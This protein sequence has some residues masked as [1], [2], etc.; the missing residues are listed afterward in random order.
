MVVV[1]FEEYKDPSEDDDGLEDGEGDGDDVEEDLDDGRVEDVA[2]LLLHFVSSDHTINP[3]I[4]FIYFRIGYVCKESIKTT[5][6]QTTFKK[7]FTN[8][9]NR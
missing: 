1:D 7:L 8:V 4:P 6:Q 3:Y 2:V 9:L 5:N